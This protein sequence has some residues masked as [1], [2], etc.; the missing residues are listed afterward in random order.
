MFHS[1]NSPTVIVGNL[2]VIST[3][4]SRR[5][6]A[7]RHNAIHPVSCRRW[8][9]VTWSLPLFLFV[10]LVCL[11]CSFGLALVCLWFV[12]GCEVL[13]A[14]LLM[15]HDVKSTMCVCAFGLPLVFLWFAFGCWRYKMETPK[16]KNKSDQNITP[17]KRTARSDAQPGDICHSR[18][19]EY[20]S[21]RWATICRLVCCFHF[22]K[23]AGDIL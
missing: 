6:L 17:L 3:L 18:R 7:G 13:G 22:A 2:G 4:S 16:R 9:H 15:H 23:P 20:I 10:P 19:S 21:R 11:W 1:G 14:H 8:Y 5:R 12:F